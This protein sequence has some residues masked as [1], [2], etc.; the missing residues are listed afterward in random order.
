MRATRVLVLLL[1][2]IAASCDEPNERDWTEAWNE[3]GTDLELRVETGFRHAGSPWFHT[4]DW[5]RDL[6]PATETGF[7]ERPSLHLRFAHTDGFTWTWLRFAPNGATLEI[8][9]ERLWDIGSVDPRTG[10]VSFRG[11]GTLL[12]GRV[13]ISSLDWDSVDEVHCEFKV[14]MLL[15][16]ESRVYR[17]SGVATREP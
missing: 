9:S 1:V 8:R 2:G 13:Q 10:E 4:E 7:F 15:E 12:G 3:T 14:A 11:E 16:G 6:Y 5:W 17:G